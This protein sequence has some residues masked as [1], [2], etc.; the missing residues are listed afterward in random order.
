[1]DKVEVAPEAVRVCDSQ[2]EPEQ[3]N[4]DRKKFITPQ[5]SV[6]VD[7]MEATTF[8]QVTDSGVTN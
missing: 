4:S 6:P 7:V 1:V 5:I 2:P 3:S 8:F